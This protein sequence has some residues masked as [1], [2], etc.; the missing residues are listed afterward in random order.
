M[1]A[2]TALVGTK[3]AVHLD[4]KS[5]IYLNLA[6]IVDPGNPKLNHSLRFDQTFENFGVSTLFAALDDRP[7][8]FQHFGHSLKK[9][10]LVGVTFFNDFENFLNE[11]HRI[12]GLICH[13]VKQKI[14]CAM[15][16]SNQRP[17]AC[18]ASA[19]PLS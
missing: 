19:L 16:V 9:L 7:D 2:Q 15:L 5:P 13:A 12:L 14:W 6:V 17:L 8:R 3:G 1:K 10:R 11:N 18:E 4:A